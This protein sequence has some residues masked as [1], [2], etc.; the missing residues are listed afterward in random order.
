MLTDWLIR[1]HFGSS[2]KI[3]SGQK[4]HSSLL[5]SNNKE[6]TPKARPLDDDPGFWE[7]ARKNG[8]GDWLE[9]DLCE[10]TGN[11][12]ESL[13]SDDPGTASQTLRECVTWGTFQI[14]TFSPWLT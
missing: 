4:I 11:L 12:V 10:Y 2:R 3:H 13:I 7:E 14:F 5:L 1:P 8:L 6:Y 9:L